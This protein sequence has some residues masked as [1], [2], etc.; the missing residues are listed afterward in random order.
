MPQLDHLI[1][2]SQIASIIVFIF[3]Y[4]IF[5]KTLLPLISMEMKLKNKMLLSNML[6]LK[7]NLPEMN[8]FRFQFSK[9]MI[10]TRGM[11]NAVN[12]IVVKKKVF[13]GIY[14]IDLYYIKHR[15]EYKK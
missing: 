5:L 13:F 8:F 2:S 7:K 15:K 6:W 11:L 9:F 10:K 3:G 4:F 1:F 12:F 14:P